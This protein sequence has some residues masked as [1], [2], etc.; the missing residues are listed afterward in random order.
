M[1]TNPSRCPNCNA[2][3]QPGARYCANCG[4]DLY[5]APPA[6]PAPGP[7][8]APGWQGSATAK[9]RIVDAVSGRQYT[10]D[11][12]PEY[13]VVLP[14]LA[15]L[16]GVV[17]WVALAII[18]FIVGSL[19][20]FLVGLVAQV[21]VLYLIYRLLKR[22]NLHMAREA[23]FRRAVID[24]FRQK[25]DEKGMTQ[26][27]YPYIAAME[28]IDRE[29]LGSE[30]PQDATLWTILCIIPIIYIVAYILIGYWL[31][32]FPPG[33]DRRFF[34]FA[35]NAQYLGGM[36]GTRIDLPPVWRPVPERSFLLYIVL[37]I[38]TLGLFAIY[39]VWVLIRDLNDHFRN[40]WEFEDRL[41]G[42]LS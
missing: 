34:A 23:S 4:H 21:L 1:S 2:E 20:V 39:W 9:Q 35:Q 26:Q 25:A 30:K 29:G 16:V 37:T 13:W 31:T 22:H 5:G 3:V 17:V 24:Y 42:A 38:I 12:I 28:S 10:D 6:T 33:H 11:I 27:A 18:G 15:S 7:G 40:E 41:I 14:I 19:I 36:L 32:T 8:A